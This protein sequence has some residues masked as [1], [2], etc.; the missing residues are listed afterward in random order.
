MNGEGVECACRTREIGILVATQ[1]RDESTT[2]LPAI[3]FSRCSRCMCVCTA[4]AGVAWCL[5][6]TMSGSTVYTIDYG[7]RG[8]T[9]CSG[10]RSPIFT[11]PDC[12]RPTLRPSE[13]HT[14]RELAMCWLA[15]GTRLVS[16]CCIIRCPASKP[17]LPRHS[18]SKVRRSLLQQHSSC[19]RGVTKAQE[20]QAAPVANRLARVPE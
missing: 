10:R 7:G 16:M 4:R 18:A 6:T 15:W 12:G 13:R 19:A 14:S 9:L 2:H 1:W 20:H 11:L 8:V 17:A 5:K 3:D